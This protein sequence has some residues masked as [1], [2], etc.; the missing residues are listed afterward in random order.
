APWAVHWSRSAALASAMRAASA[1]PSS[2]RTSE[3]AP[4]IAAISAATWAWWK[5]TTRE[6][7]TATAASKTTTAIMIPEEAMVAYPDSSIS[8]LRTIITAHLSRR[9]RLRWHSWCR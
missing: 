2:P 8:F 6:I 3:Y 9:E 5:A 4:E 7:I 1:Q